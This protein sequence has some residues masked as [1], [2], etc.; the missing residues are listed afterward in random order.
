LT[1]QSRLLELLIFAGEVRRKTEELSLLA[2]VGISARI[3][4][5]G[6]MGS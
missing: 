5:K 1:Q 2:E 3:V 6:G 4:D